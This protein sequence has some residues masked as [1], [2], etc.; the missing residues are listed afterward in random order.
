MKLFGID[1]DRFKM[2]L[3]KVINDCATTMHGDYD[4]ARVVGYPFCIAVALLFIFGTVYST[5]KTGSFNYVGFAA[6]ATGSSSVIL[7]VSAAVAVKS[8]TER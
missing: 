3:Y 4:P 2:I 6:G 8:H 7:S 1:T 5:L